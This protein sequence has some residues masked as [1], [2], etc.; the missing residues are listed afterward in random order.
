MNREEFISLL[1]LSQSHETEIAFFN[2]LE[3]IGLIHIEI[4]EEAPYVHKEQVR[5]I[6]RMI[7]LHQDLKVDAEA[8][9]IIFNLLEKIDSLQRELEAARHKSGIHEKE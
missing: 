2:G 7:R 8:I 9:D 6:E 3:D 4:I 1:H 5:D